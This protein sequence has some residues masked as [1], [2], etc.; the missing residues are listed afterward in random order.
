MGH[1]LRRAGVT[2]LVGAVVFGAVYGLAASLTIE[3][4]SLGAGNHAVAAC[5]SGTLTVEYATAYE[6]ALPGYKVSTVTVTGLEAGCYAKPY[7]ITLI[8]NVN[9]S[10][11][12]QSGT[13]PSSGSF[14]TSAFAGTVSAAAVTGVH[15]V[16]AG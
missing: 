4:K 11:G 15:V 9:A 5:Q 10:L 1:R 16:I 8:N 6:S 12:E 3:S 14:T 2:L 13:T 7:K